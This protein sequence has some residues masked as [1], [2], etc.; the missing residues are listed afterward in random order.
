MS[1]HAFYYAGDR[2]EGIERA[3]AYG[4]RS[5]GLA[6]T[7]NPDVVV[8]RYELFPVEDARK[9]GELASRVP[10]KGEAKLIVI[11]ATRLFHESQNALLKVFEE[12]AP[13]TTIILIVPSE[14]VIIPTLRSRLIELSG[15]SEAEKVPE[16]VKA[17][18]E[19]NAAER[20]KLVAKLLDRAKSDKAEEKQ[21]ARSEALALASGLMRA[22]YKKREDSDTRAFLSDL[23]R[24]IPILH[25]RSAPLKPIFEHLLMTIP[26]GLGR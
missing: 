13:G 1:H 16:H 4:T 12:P 15:D 3:L 6:P 25:E 11:A 14:G 17:F 9:I 22:A 20:E 24:F 2:E 18:L 19:G 5:L 7:G 8:L 23:D 26:A 10:S 21:A